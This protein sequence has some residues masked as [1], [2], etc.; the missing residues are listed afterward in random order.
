MLLRSIDSP[1]CAIDLSP[2]LVRVYNE[3]LGVEG[4]NQQKSLRHLNH[5]VIKSKGLTN[6][7]CG[8]FKLLLHTAVK[9]KRKKH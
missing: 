2:W 4:R 5:H 9:A 1:E 6:I 8:I 7:F 3:S